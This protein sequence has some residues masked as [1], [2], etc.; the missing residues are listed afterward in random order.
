MSSA[1]S[2][3][4]EALD[5]YV[6]GRVNAERL[7][8]VVAAA[9]YGERERGKG[10]GLRPLVELIER[11]APGSVELARSDGGAGFDIKPAARAF[12]KEYESE[13]RAVVEAVLGGSGKGEEGRVTPSPGLLARIMQ[14]IRR[15][16]R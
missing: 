2:A 7:V 1:T 9:Y 15:L 13:L 4:R 14:A 8:A 3:V 6:A 12:P 10:E 16:F 5:G 11:A